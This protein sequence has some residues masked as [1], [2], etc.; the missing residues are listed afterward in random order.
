MLIDD[1]EKV[2]SALGPVLCYAEIRDP[3]QR[4]KTDAYSNRDLI[5]SRSAGGEM[6]SLLNEV[7][8]H[9]CKLSGH[10]NLTSKIDAMLS[11]LHN[12]NSAKGRE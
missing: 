3:W 8:M 7:R 11:R 1:I 6:V 10:G 4:I 2:E 9:L 5:Q 12:I